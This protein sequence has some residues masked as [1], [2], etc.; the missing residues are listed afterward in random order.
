MRAQR[1]LIAACLLVGA[2]GGLAY[3]RTQGHPTVATAQLL[4][5]VGPDYRA[6]DVDL[7]P[8]SLD[9]IAQLINTP[10]V[11]D[12]VERASGET[13]VPGPK[14]LWVTATANSRL[15]QVHFASQHPARPATGVAAAAARCWR[16][17]RA[18]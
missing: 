17:A 2:V 10:A 15:L 12:A 7:P 16:R 14:R 8:Q 6:A 13:V 1:V 18:C 4:T 11:V 9:T 3:D 5:P